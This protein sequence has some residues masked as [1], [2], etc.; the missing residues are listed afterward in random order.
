MSSEASARGLD[1]VLIGATTL[2]G[3]DVRRRLVER[4]FPLRELSMMGEGSEVGQEEREE[5]AGGRDTRHQ[6][7]QSRMP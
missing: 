3:Q 4:R 5:A 7:G 6:D 1:V 2:L